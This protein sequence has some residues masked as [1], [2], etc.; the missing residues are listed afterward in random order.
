MDKLT[1]NDSP[2]MIHVTPQSEVLCQASGSVT[3]RERNARTSLDKLSLADSGVVMSTEMQPNTSNT[4]EVSDS[5][6]SI[7]STNAETGCRVLTEDHITSGSKM[8][9]ENI[10]LCASEK[11][12]LLP[13]GVIKVS[14]PPP[15]SKS[16]S[17]LPADLLSMVTKLVRQ[18]PDL[19]QDAVGQTGRGKRVREYEESLTKRRRAVECHSTGV[20]ENESGGPISTSSSEPGSVHS[21]PLL[22]QS[23]DAPDV[24][25]DMK[26]RQGE[27]VHGNRQPDGTDTASAC[28]P[29][30]ACNADQVHPVSSD[31]STESTAIHFKDITAFAD[32]DKSVHTDGA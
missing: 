25:T 16:A 31:S 23:D 8:H 24:K 17:R 28:V 19:S 22:S 13:L 20:G 21:S 7:G 1:L 29:S 4:R 3:L 26:H 12:P 27:K 2:R 6:Q 9:S 5:V 32:T 11:T 10:V 18:N 30:L 15:A 14:G